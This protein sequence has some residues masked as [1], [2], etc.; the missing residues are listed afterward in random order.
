MASE[1]AV[2][3]AD[4]RLHRLYAWFDPESTAV[5]TILLG[6][7]QI[8]LSAPLAHSSQ[9]LPELFILPIV[10][11]IL[12]MAGGSFTM[13]NERNPSR[14]LLQGC[15]YSNVVGLLGVLL[16]FCLY[17]YTLSTS[18]DETSCSA[19]L[20]DNEYFFN[21]CPSKF[22]TAYSR[23]VTLLLLLCD[24]GAM[25]MHCLLSVFAFKTLKA[26]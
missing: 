17:C 16:A 21:I 6:L 18:H 4:T 24:T 10:L 13:A 14:L 8:V 7:L 26:N 2:P 20:A 5:I 23:S 15:A 1:G 11:G 19:F 9:T 22:L 3:A 25:V 12:I